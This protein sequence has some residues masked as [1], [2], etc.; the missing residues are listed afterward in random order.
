VA[1]ENIQG[2]L[3]SNFQLSLD[4]FMLWVALLMVAVS[5]WPFGCVH[6]LF[7]LF[8]SYFVVAIAVLWCGMLIWSEKLL[9]F[10]LRRAGIPWL[11]L[12]ALTAIVAIPLLP[13]PSTWTDTI[14]PSVGSWMEKTSPSAREQ[15]AAV[16]ENRSQQIVDNDSNGL[17]N[18][19]PMAQATGDVAIASVAIAP[20]ASAHGSGEKDSSFAER[21][22]N[23]IEVIDLPASNL[24]GGGLS[25][26]PAG[27]LQFVFRL[28]ALS[29]LFLALSGI[30]QAERAVREL[31]WLATV[32]G[33]A[34]AF[35]AILQSIS[36]GRN[37][38]YWF[39]ES[40]GSEYGPFLNKNHYP[41]FAN[42]AI[43]LSIGL[44]LERWS[45]CGLSWAMLFRDSTALWILASLSLQ[46]TSLA[47]SLSR[48]G[49]FSLIVAFVI[50]MILRAK[51]SPGAPIVFATVFFGAIT[52]VM[53]SWAGFSLLE[54]RLVTLTEAGTYR[55]DGRWYLWRVAASVFTEFPLF[56]SGGETYRHWQTIIQYGGSW[57]SS[58]TFA[59][60]ADNEYLDVLC[61]HGIFASMA[62][63]GLIVSL[64]VSCG[65]Q[66]LTDKQSDERLDG[67]GLGSSGLGS[68]GLGSSGLVA[69]GLISLLSV[70]IHS[71]VDFGLR[72]PASAGFAVVV[73]ALINAARPTTL[74]LAKLQSIQS[75]S[76]RLI[77]WL[78]P[79]ISIGVIV[80]VF[81][82]L[83]SFVRHRQSY[84]DSE[85]H[86]LEA[87]AAVSKKD[88]DRVIVEIESMVQATPEDVLAH[89]EYARI[90]LLAT[91]FASPPLAS[92][93]KREMVRHCVQ[94][95]D[96]CP[97]VWESPF[98]I[99]QNIDQL[100]NSD[101]VDY[102]RIAHRLHPS[103]STISYLLGVE[104]FDRL[105]DIDMAM[106]AWKG[107]LLYSPRYLKEILGRA[108]T[109]FTPQEVLDHILPAN[110]ATLVSAAAIVESMGQAESKNEFLRRAA[111]A[112]EQSLPSIKPHE[113]YTTYSQAADIQS[114]LGDTDRAVEFSR[115][116]IS[117]APTNINVRFQLVRYL[118]ELRRLE[119]AKLELN[120]IQSFDSSNTQILQL[121]NQIFELE[122][123]RIKK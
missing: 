107:S 79:V 89:L 46:L 87:Y 1:N 70:A 22:S 3:L 52:V 33:S 32:I 101:S 106:D 95:R 36:P 112:I 86:R 65:K 105:I 98:W 83:N 48:G 93:L 75:Q 99:S 64:M 13:I 18:P 31:A 72:V 41:F 111:V 66:A 45:A 116:A 63:V 91:K 81:A 10:S 9:E 80:A 50:V 102:L 23:P 100:V 119:E 30:T 8:L 88:A 2:Y 92:V 15:L 40:K 4:R 56:G 44:L 11:F 117:S 49:V 104:L 57:N 61:E 38:I 26:N 120:R 27:N 51:R 73:A 12:V 60:R 82:F 19:K 114:K 39:F 115:Q 42:L 62:L 53:M 85:S 90:A 55:E 43:G 35:V 17:S 67:S 122:H 110:A 118:I 20:G 34:L 69:G 78:W 5:P 77:R 25:L 24:L 76:S 14:S 97:L 59:H 7:E 121:R 37:E 123:P 58:A 21:D 16:V 68:S 71:F 103:N 84:A 96:L 113:L 28:A 6:P 29:L 108:L 94:L 109:K 74:S 54:S 47:M